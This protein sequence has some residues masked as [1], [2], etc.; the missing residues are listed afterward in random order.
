M[1]RSATRNV[2]RWAATLYAGHVQQLGGNLV[3]ANLQD[4]NLAHADFSN[5]SLWGPSVMGSICSALVCSEQIF[6]RR[7]FAA[8]SLRSVKKPVQVSVV[9]ICATVL[10]TELKLV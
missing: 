2:R 1:L 3:G 7:H 8:Q 6:T 10:S 4:L 9:L 5:V